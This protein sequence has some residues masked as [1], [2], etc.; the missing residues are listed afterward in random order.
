MRLIA[1]FFHSACVFAVTD[2]IPST[3]MD[4]EVLNRTQVAVNYALGE[5]NDAYIF[6]LI[7]AS[8]GSYPTSIQSRVMQY[9]L[10]NARERLVVGPGL[11]LFGAYLTQ[12]WIGTGFCDERSGIIEGLQT[13]YPDPNDQLYVGLVCVGTLAPRVTAS[14]VVTP[15]PEAI[16]FQ[17]RLRSLN[18]TL[19]PAT[20]TIQTYEVQSY[21]SVI[22]AA[23]AIRTMLTDST[24][25]NSQNNG[26]TLQNAINY[27]L[28][29]QPNALIGIDGTPMTF[30]TPVDATPTTAAINCDSTQPLG[31]YNWN[32]SKGDFWI[33]GFL[34]I[35]R[36]TLNYSQTD[37]IFADGSNEYPKDRANV[38]VTGDALPPHTF[39]AKM[40]VLGF[41]VSVIGAWTGMILCKSTAHAKKNVCVA[42]GSALLTI[43]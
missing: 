10:T 37:F 1:C 18:A 38:Y 2:I 29:T 42:I 17:N 12:Q 5:S 25:S 36:H 32:P 40:V 39:D 20:Y 23:A 15:V 35:D 13:T 9:I 34:D 7:G 33:T 24:F 26:T 19:F 21:N 22:F 30:T 4:F 8:T 6:V 28:R 14:P 3:R 41:C 11:N 43:C 27:M 31:I 16:A